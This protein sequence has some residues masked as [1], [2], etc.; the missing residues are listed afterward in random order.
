MGGGAAAAHGTQAACPPSLGVGAL[1]FRRGW[2][3]P[4]QG[5][6]ASPARHRS[7]AGRQQYFPFSALGGVQQSRRSRLEDVAGGVDPP[8][9]TKAGKLVS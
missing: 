8:A 3:S 7:P 6:G 5:G 4:W 2:I 9:Y 1:M